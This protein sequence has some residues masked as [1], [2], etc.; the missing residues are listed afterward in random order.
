MVGYVTFRYDDANDIHFAYPK[1]LVETEDD[2]RIW[3][4][5]FVDHFSKYGKKVDVVIV[6]DDFRIGPAIGSVWGKYRAEWIRT[7][8]RFSVRVNGDR[9]AS[10][11]TAT[12]AALY[13]GGYQEAPD[14]ETA[15]K[16]ILAW[17]RAEGLV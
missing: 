8:T 7:Y 17:R 11:F 10:T 16:N 6:L 5:Q 12:S 14:V 3:Y 9:R 13:G 15:V 2:C 4:Q 1:W